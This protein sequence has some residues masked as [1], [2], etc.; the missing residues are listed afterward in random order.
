MYFCKQPIMR[1]FEKFHSLFFISKYR[2]KGTSDITYQL[3]LMSFNNSQNTYF[4]NYPT[5]Q[6]ITNSETAQNQVISL[7]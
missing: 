3:E 1:K 2:M 7:A 5:I 6:N 4:N